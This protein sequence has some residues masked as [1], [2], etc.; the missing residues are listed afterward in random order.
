[1][2]DFQTFWR[3]LTYWTLLLLDIPLKDISSGSTYLYRL[4]PYKPHNTLVLQILLLMTSFVLSRYLLWLL[5]VII[6]RCG[7][8]IWY[9]CIILIVD[10]TSIWHVLGI[11]RLLTPQMEDRASKGDIMSRI[12]EVKKIYKFSIWKWF[13]I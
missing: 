7:I 6:L 1:M 9:D 5:Q 12:L 8:M 4:N 10:S 11:F 13:S 3:W 2:Q